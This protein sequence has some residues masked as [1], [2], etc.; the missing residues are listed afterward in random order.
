M[1][2][3]PVEKYLHI[4]AMHRRAFPTLSAKSLSSAKNIFR[5]HPTLQPKENTTSQVCFSL[6]P[7]PVSLVE[8]YALFHVAPLPFKISKEQEVV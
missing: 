8:L 7:K 6:C 5:Q 2:Q 1:I 4:E 3:F